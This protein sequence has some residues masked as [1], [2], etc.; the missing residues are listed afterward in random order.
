MKETGLNSLQ[1]TKTKMSHMCL[2]LGKKGNLDRLQPRVSSQRMDILYPLHLVQSPVTDSILSTSQP[3][4]NSHTCSPQSQTPGEGPYSPWDFS[5]LHYSLCHQRTKKSEVLIWTL[6][7]E[8]GLVRE[9]VGEEWLQSYCFELP[10][11]SGLVV[12]FSHNKDSWK[13]EEEEG[14]LEG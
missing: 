2:G 5:K 9:R 11:V 8:G 14:I 3:Q 6:C 10:W 4:D 7:K 1:E 12:P 13:T